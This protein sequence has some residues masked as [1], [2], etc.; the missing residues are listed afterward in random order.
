MPIYADLLSDEDLAALRQL[1]SEGTAMRAKLLGRE[2]FGHRRLLARIRREMVTNL[3]KAIEPAT[4][5]EYE[6]FLPS[7]KASA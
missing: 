7:G 3:R 5:A 6:K 1:E 4:Q 2:I